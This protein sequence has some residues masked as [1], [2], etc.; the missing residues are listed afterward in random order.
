MMTKKRNDPYEQQKLK[1]HQRYLGARTLKER[2]PNVL[3]IKVRMSF[4]PYDSEDR[5]LLNDKEESFCPGSRA[6]FE[7]AC[8][9]C[10]CIGGGFELLD[11]SEMVAKGKTEVS[12]TAICK[13]WQDLERI[14]K[15]QCRLKMNYRI[16]VIYNSDT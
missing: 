3:E 15:F 5:N 13:G 8:P 2:Y 4:E 11:V 12:G 10:E 14:N 9:F 1:R 16:T 6:F 7:F